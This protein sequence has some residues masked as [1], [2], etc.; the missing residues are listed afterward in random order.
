MPTTRRARARQLAAAAAAAI[1]LAGCWDAEVVRISYTWLPEQGIFWSEFSYENLELDSETCGTVD[2]CVA[3]IVRSM[4]SAARDAADVLAERGIT[5]DA[6]AFSSWLVREGDEMHW[7]G[8]GAMSVESAAEAG[9][10]VDSTGRLVL[11]PDADSQVLLGSAWPA[12]LDAEPGNALLLPAGA[13]LLPAQDDR[14]AAWLLPP[15]ETRIALRAREPDRDWPPAFAQLPGLEAAL[16]A[17]GVRIEEH[18][19]DDAEGPPLG[20]WA[21]YWN[22]PEPWMRD[23]ATLALRSDGGR[24]TAE[25]QLSGLPAVPLL[26]CTAM[27]RDGESWRLGLAAADGSATVEI[28]IDADARLTGAFELR[29]ADRSWTGDLRLV[30]VSGAPGSHG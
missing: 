30:R 14:P 29:D 8:H 28:T 20:G 15:G 12:P 25:L 11:E 23:Y 18:A 2:G 4:E 16:R 1:L 10:G 9:L 24:I 5:D 22:V 3:E 6:L 7:R 27:A 13:T 19:A 21:G 17:A 26:D